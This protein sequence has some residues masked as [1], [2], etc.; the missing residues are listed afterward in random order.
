MNFTRFPVVNPPGLLNVFVSIAAHVAVPVFIFI[1]GR[2]LALR[3][4]GAYSV[5]AYYRRRAR[6]ILPPYLL[7]T[8]L[9]LLI[10]AEGAIRFAGMPD[11][12]AVAGA[13]LMGTAAYHLW[14]FVLII[15][16]YLFYPLII[17]GYDVFDRAGAAFFLLLALLFCQVL[18]NMGAHVA[19]AFAGTEWYSVLIR[20]VP[21]HLFYFVF[22]IHVARHTGWFRSAVRSLSPAWVV[23]AAGAGALLTGGVWVAP[24]LLHGSFS[25]ATLAV[26]CVYRIVEP[27][28]Y[29][30][31]IVLLIMA[32]MRFE[33]T[34]GLLADSS[35]SFG[36]H[37]FGIYLIHP[38]IIAA[39]AA[40][41][42]TFTGL[43]WTDWVTYP[44]LFAMTAAVSYGLARVAAPRSR[45]GPGRSGGT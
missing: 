4:S 37:S 17:R 2:V 16:L 1:S 28:Y 13:L 29:I 7:F 44:V 22:G 6:T 10:P 36:E 32:A 31:V 26:F 23:V 38:I 15:Q 41:W 25:C 5:P 34:G 11:P 20:L 21:S 24:M 42:T 18:W 19:G 45:R 3:Y 14:F 43:S 35:R 12:G 39:L 9:Y 8:A 27:L 30:P 40:A 33:M